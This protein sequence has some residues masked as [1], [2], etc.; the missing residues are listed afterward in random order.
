MKKIPAVELNH[1]YI[2]KTVFT[3]DKGSFSTIEFLAVS[4]HHVVVCTR[5][6]RGVEGTTLM[7]EPGDFVN[8]ADREDF[9]LAAA[10]G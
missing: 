5:D 2:G 9:V 3:D 8:M 7:L 1:S 10:K 6:P 4:K